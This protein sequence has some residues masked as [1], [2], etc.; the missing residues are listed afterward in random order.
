MSFITAILIKPT[1]AKS[2]ILYYVT[3][4]DPGGSFPV[5][6]IN[7]ATR[8]IAPKFI[9]KIYKA[10]LKYEKWKTKH[11]P[12]FMPWVNPEQVAVPRI[13]WNDI[14]PMD[15]NQFKKNQVD[16]SQISENQI[17]DIDADDD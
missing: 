5:W 16:E 8:V 6:V 3:Q 7:S 11:N 12:N 1:S 10:A 2:C 13:D 9:K 4:S 17:Q 15:L 14:Q